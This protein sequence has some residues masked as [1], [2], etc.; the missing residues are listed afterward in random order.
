MKAKHEETILVHL[1]AYRDPELVPTI[2]DC[3]ARAKYPERVHF[4]ICRQYNPDDGWDDVTEFKTDPR[5]NIMEVHY[6]QAKGLP[7]A[8]A[9]INDILMTDQDYV[10]QLDSHHRFAEGWDE[11]LID[12][13]TGLEAEGWRPVIGGYLPLYTPFN[14][15]GGRAMVPYQSQFRCFYPEFHTIFIGPAGLEGWENMTKPIRAR[16]LSGHFCF[17]R[18]AWA[19]EVRHDPNIYFAGEEINLTVRSFTHGWDLFGL[20]KLVIWH[21]TM[22]EERSGIC[23]WDDDSRRRLDW[24][25][26]ENRGRYR[27][28]VML[29]AADDPKVDLG[30]YGLG[31]ARTV[32]DY[33]MYAGVCF[34]ERSAQQYTFDNKLPPNPFKSSYQEFLGSLKKSFYYVVNIERQD[35]P[36]DDYQRILVAFDDKAGNGMNFRDI[37]PYKGPK[38]FRWDEHNRIHYAEYFAVEEWP[39]RVVY[40]AQRQNGEWAE[41]VE[42][43]IRFYD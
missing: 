27:I 16:F 18:A 39:V 12:M 24:T 26:I 15:P 14:D 2:R 13:Y 31:T 22:R 37:D 42:T 5:F 19:R 36:R 41:R 30:P 29:G 23:K 7:W 1:P 28:K 32:R 9:Q 3:L 4:G 43:K 10:L 11:T 33:E 8:R 34:K 21:S 6:T 25:A 17:A 20:H 40:W 35:F 38:P